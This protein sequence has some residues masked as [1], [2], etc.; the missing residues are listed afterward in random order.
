MSQLT[1]ALLA[2]CEFCCCWKFWKFTLSEW[3]DNTQTIVKFMQRNLPS[4]HLPVNRTLVCG[5]YEAMFTVPKLQCH[6]F[7]G[8][9]NYNYQ[10]Q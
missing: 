10:D 3:I 8:S 9:K 2:A 5:N 7:E 4:N 1:P 6:Q